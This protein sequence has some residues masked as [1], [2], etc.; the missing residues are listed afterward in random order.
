LAGS[1]TRLIGRWGIAGLAWS[2][3]AARLVPWLIRLV[4]GATHVRGRRFSGRCLSNL[5]MCL[6]CGSGTQTL[7][8][9]PL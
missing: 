5:R 7:Y 1:S 9:P 4:P 3:S 6:S 2:G 8:F